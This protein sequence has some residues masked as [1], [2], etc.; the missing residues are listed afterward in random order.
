MFSLIP[1]RNSQNNEMKCIYIL[2]KH[3]NAR[4]VSTKKKNE[5]LAVMKDEICKCN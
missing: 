3:K 1:S 5:S 2:H 4:L